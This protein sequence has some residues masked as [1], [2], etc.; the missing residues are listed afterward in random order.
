[1]KGEYFR[2][3]IG[4][5]IVLSLLLIS[6][7]S[8]AGLPN[9]NTTSELEINVSVNQVTWVDITP[10]SLNWTSPALSPG[11]TGINQDI[12]I[13]NVGSD[14]ISYLWFNS[15]HPSSNPFGT[16][17]P[18][19]YNAGNFVAIKQENGEG[20]KGSYYFFPNRHEWNETVRLAFASFETDW[21]YGRVREA[22]H[23]YV[24]SVDPSAGGDANKCNDTATSGTKGVL[25]VAS[26][27]KNRTQTGTT[28]FTDSGT[29]YT[30]ANLT[31]ST[32]YP[33]WSFTPN[34]IEIGEDSKQY[35]VAVRDSCDEVI[36][37]KWNADAPGGAADSASGYGFNCSSG[38]YFGANGTSP[39]NP[40]DAF[41]AN[42]VVYVPYGTAYGDMASGTLTMVASNI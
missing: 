20:Q 34:G 13:E 3:I 18:I 32:T 39:M 10:K 11:E 41:V 5:I 35:C 37:Y 16:G 40:G 2:A 7:T 26:T 15:T 22:N 31:Q 9:I 42:V 27:A 4:G 33:E 1:M 8:Y 21:Y 25:R 24:W 14:N 17:S 23:E 19:N 29:D 6:S 36:V 30:W 12:Y 28:D 38:S